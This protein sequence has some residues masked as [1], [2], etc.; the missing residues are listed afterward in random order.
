MPSPIEKI[1]T[2]KFIMLA[3]R[4][5][6]V[7]MCIRDRFYNTKKPI[8]RMTYLESGQK[9]C[10]EENFNIMHAQNISP[11]T[12]FNVDYKARGTRCLLYTSRCV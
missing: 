4:L 7:K 6:T 12:G 9:R 11:T 10:R 3:S 1:L 2:L 5:P 8:I